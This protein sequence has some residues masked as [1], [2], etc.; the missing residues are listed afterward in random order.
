MKAKK[1]TYSQEQDLQLIK[2]PV[3]SSSAVADLDG[4]RKIGP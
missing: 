2:L 3:F 1:I 4:L